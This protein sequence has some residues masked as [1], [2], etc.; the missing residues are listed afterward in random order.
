M[1]YDLRGSGESTKAC[2][3]QQLTASSVIGEGCLSIPRKTQGREASSTFQTLMFR[4][5]ISDIQNLIY[6]THKTARLL[7]EPIGCRS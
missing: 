6:T 1:V 3:L 7:Q 5:H 4:S 2:V